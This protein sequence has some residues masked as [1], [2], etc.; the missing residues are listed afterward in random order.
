MEPTL[1]YWVPLDGETVIWAFIS[2]RMHKL[3]DK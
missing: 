3:M 2:C 1:R